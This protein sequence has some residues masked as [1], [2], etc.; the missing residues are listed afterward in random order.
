MNAPLVSLD[1][2]EFEIIQISAFYKVEGIIFAKQ[3]SHYKKNLFE[4]FKLQWSLGPIS[5]LNQT[6]ANRRLDLVRGCPD[7]LKA[8]SIRST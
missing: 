3:Q 7:R 6:I 2:N 8:N 5:E 1:F 4:M